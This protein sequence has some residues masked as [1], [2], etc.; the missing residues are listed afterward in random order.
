MAVFPTYREILSEERDR[1]FSVS[2]TA[3]FAASFPFSSVLPSGTFSERS[4]PASSASGPF[5]CS[6]RPPAASS[7]ASSTASCAGA[8]ALSACSAPSVP[9]ASPASPDPAFSS[10]SPF[11][12]PSAVTALSASLPLC[13]FPA[14]SGSAALSCAPP[15]RSSP[16]PGAASCPVCPVS[17]AFSSASSEAF[18]SSR[19][20][21]SASAFSSDAPTVSS[22]FSGITISVERLSAAA[23]KAVISTDPIVH[24]TIRITASSFASCCLIILMLRFR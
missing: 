20:C 2:A 24:E 19:S 21:R 9:G 15:E 12:S 13:A 23:A 18:S 6:F 1:L 8:S 10:F 14:V 5:S 7:G 16:S 17:S 22:P 3:S 4:L 11:P